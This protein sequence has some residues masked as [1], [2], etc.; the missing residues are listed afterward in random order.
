MTFPIPGP[1]QRPDIPKFVVAQ[2]LSVD[3]GGE[4][5]L[6][7]VKAAVRTELAQRGGIHR[8][9]ETLRKQTYVSVLLDKPVTGVPGDIKPQ[10]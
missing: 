1:A 2:L 9:V 8:Y 4:R 7:E 10:P 6:P 5:T 3:E